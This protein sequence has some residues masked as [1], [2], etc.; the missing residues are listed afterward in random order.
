VVLAAGA[1]EAIVATVWSHLDKF[2]EEDL[3]EKIR[4]LITSNSPS[5]IISRNKV[6]DWTPYSLGLVVLGVIN[7]PVTPE[8]RSTIF[9]LS[10][11]QQSAVSR[12]KKRKETDELQLDPKSAYCVTLAIF[13]GEELG[14]KPILRKSIPIEMF[15]PP[16]PWPKSGNAG[17]WVNERYHPLSPPSKVP[18]SGD[19]L[20]DISGDVRAGTNNL[21]I[22]FGGITQSSI[23]VLLHHPTSTQLDVWQEE[24]DFENSMKQFSEQFR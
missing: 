21:S 11:E 4:G 12:W 17:A 18:I 13:P 23:A 16:I 20:Y 22:A 2:E 10:A 6:M 5:K 14:S 19:N 3:R 8:R 7:A 9:T 1:H 15:E 24:K